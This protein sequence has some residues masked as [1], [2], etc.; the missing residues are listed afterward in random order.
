MKKVLFSGVAALA[1]LAAGTTVAS[2]DQTGDPDAFICPV[3]GEGVLNNAAR[4]GAGPYPG[5]GATF[6]PGKEQAGRHA[7]ANALNESGGPS[8]TNRPG[9][10]GFTPIWNPIP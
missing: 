3:V 10:D 5:G 8:A 2:A 1:L 7:N 4:T 9:A 6:T